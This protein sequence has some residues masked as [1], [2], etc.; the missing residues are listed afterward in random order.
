[1][2][3]PETIPG[4]VPAHSKAWYEQLSLQKGK[5]E[6]EWQSTVTE[7]NG[8]TVFDKLVLDH[9]AGQRVV[10]IGCGHGAFARRCSQVAA[11]VT[12]YDRVERF[13]EQ[14]WEGAR[15]NVHFVVGSGDTRQLP[16]KGG[17]FQLAYIRKGPTS[18]Y[19]DIARVVEKGG[20]VFGLHPG[21]RLGQELPILFPNLYEPVKG[22]PILSKLQQR[23]AESGFSESHC[24]EILSVE[25][26]KRPID[27]IKM[28][29]FGQS[30]EVLATLTRRALPEV[31]RVFAAKATSR[32]LALTHARYLVRARV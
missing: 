18:A 21:D 3:N 8:E 22:T 14:A 20:F 26:I 13:I 5:Y 19:L 15:A 2:T 10:D 27:V 32:G 1:M 16:F 7:P 29:A 11:K 12:G 24:E 31:E 17:E 30:S 28:K 6:Y 23:L 4:W 25:Y 9:S